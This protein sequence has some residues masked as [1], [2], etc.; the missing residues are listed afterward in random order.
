MAVDAAARLSAA[1]RPVLR[2]GTPLCTS[3]PVVVLDP[4]LKPGRYQVQLRVQGDA[5][6][7]AVASLWIQL[8][9]S[10]PRVVTDADTGS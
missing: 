6:T 4:A 1:S 3:V 5:A 2:P 10:V 8:E 9:P 7:S